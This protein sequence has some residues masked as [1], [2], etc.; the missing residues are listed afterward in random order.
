VK[1]TTVA[2][3]AAKELPVSILEKAAVIIPVIS[4]GIVIIYISCTSTP[5]II[6]ITAKIPIKTAVNI[7][8]VIMVI[9]TL[10]K[11]VIGLDK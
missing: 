8:L 1:F 6:F 2:T 9:F 5:A 7:K 3:A 4:Q 11:E 10:C